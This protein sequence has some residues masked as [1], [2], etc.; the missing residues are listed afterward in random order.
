MAD[1]FLIPQ[2]FNARRFD[3]DMAPYPTLCAIEAA[4]N[5]LPAFEQAHPAQQPDAA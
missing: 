4:C 3:V 1:C 5:A 2:I